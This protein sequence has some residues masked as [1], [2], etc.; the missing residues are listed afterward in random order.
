MVWWVSALGS[1]LWSLSKNMGICKSSG[2]RL[3][4]LSTVLENRFFFFPLLSK[5][6]PNEENIRNKESQEGGQLQKIGLHWPWI[7]NVFQE[8][9]ISW[10]ASTG[11]GFFKY[12]LRISVFQKLKILKNQKKKSFILA[13][14]ITSTLLQHSV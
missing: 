2:R 14:N 12:S 7:I 6:Y 13:T 9:C 1:D 8:G 11:F 5:S 10:W 4:I 3:K